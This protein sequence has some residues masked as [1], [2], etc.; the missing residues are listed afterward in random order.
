MS[1]SSRPGVTEPAPECLGRYPMVAGCL[2]YCAAV[3][4]IRDGVLD[5]L[6]GISGHPS[7]LAA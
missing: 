6:F 2:A 5:V 4:D 7:G 1:L 3:K